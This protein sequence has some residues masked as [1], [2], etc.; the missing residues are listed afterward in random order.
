MA[1]NVI[2]LRPDY[3]ERYRF[4]QQRIQSIIESRKAERESVIKDLKDAAWN[5]QVELVRVLIAQKS[6]L[7]IVIAA[8]EK[9]YQ[10]LD[11]QLQLAEAEL[12]RAKQAL[13]LLSNQ[14]KDILAKIEKHRQQAQ[15]LE[16]E[17]Q[18]HL[19]VVSLIEQKIKALRDL[20]GVIEK[21]ELAPLREN[22]KECREELKRFLGRTSNR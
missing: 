10:S 14:E 3:Q 8:Q 4:E 1:A 20:N 6:A 22:I 13:D 18:E 15:A 5:D 9:R 12:N 2:E 7:D 17:R 16:Q 21:I 11:R 19:S